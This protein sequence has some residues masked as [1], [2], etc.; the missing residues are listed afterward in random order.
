MGQYVLFG[1]ISM[2]IGD[3]PKDRFLSSGHPLLQ[4]RAQV[5]SFRAQPPPLRMKSEMYPA[6]NTNAKTFGSMPIVAKTCSGLVSVCSGSGTGSSM[7]GK[8]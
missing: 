6:T 3:I 5:S 8:Y 4:A 1:E 2:G 7:D